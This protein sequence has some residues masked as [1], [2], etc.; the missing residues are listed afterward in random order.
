M[1]FACFGIAGVNLNFIC[2]RGNIL[3]IGY[4]I[5]VTCG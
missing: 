2:T 4:K 1:D 5:I 3:V